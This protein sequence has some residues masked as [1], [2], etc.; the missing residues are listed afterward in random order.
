MSILC[1]YLLR[2]TDNHSATVTVTS[3]IDAEPVMSTPSNFPPL[4]T[5]LFVVP[6]KNPSVASNACL[7]EGPHSGAWACTDGPV[8]RLKIVP[9]GTGLSLVYVESGLMPN[10]FR[11]GAQPPELTYPADVMIMNDKDDR[12]KGPAYFFQE[13]YT[14]L[15]VLRPE[16]FEPLLKRWSKQDAE[17]LEQLETRKRG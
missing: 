9:R 17:V 1:L 13:L 5:G 6:M 10:V 15:V 11:Y 3:I 8:V 7:S 14:K 12:S 16:E 4:P 2:S